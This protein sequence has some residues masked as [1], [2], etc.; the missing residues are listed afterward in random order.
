MKR[1]DFEI[2]VFCNRQCKVLT[3]FGKL[4]LIHMTIE[5]VVYHPITN[6]LEAK[7]ITVETTPFIFSILYK[8]VLKANDEEG[9]KSFDRLVHIG[10]I[11]MLD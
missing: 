5:K 10:W 4:H 9:K 11:V 2:M 7:I 3:A 8:L 6:K 1:E